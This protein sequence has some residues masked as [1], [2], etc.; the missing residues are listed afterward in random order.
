MLRQLVAIALLPFTVT[1]LVPLWI[2]RAYGVELGWGDS[3]AERALQLGGVG[4]LGVGLALFVASLRRF[5]AEGKGTLAPWDPPRGTRRARPV[6]LRAQPD[7]LG[8]DL[9]A[10]RRGARGALAPHAVWAGFFL[11]LNLTYIP[12]FEEPQLAERSESPIATTAST[13]GASGRGCARGSAA[14]GSPTMT[15]R[16]RTGDR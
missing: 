1:I 11:A 8:R 16:A 12:L 5:A 4:L 9:R 7:D 15:V 14:D 2:A 13:C 6:S 10:V 3:L